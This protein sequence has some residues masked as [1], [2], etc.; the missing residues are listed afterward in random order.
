MEE[1]GMLYL[2]PDD[3][4]FRDLLESH[5]ISEGEGETMATRDY[6]K[7]N[8]LT[9]CDVEEIGL[10]QSLSMVEWAG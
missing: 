4:S 2:Y 8:F 9:E 7:V 5:G 1:I 10:W 6:V 3:P